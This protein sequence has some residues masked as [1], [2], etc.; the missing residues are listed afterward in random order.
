MDTFLT[1]NQ[2]FAKF[3]SKRIQKAVRGITGKKSE[4]M[5]GDFGGKVKRKK[6]KS[7]RET[8]SLGENEGGN[9]G[10]IPEE[11]NQIKGKKRGRKPTKKGEKKSKNE[12]ESES[13]EE[14]KVDQIIEEE[15]GKKMVGFPFKIII[16]FFHF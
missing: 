9:D 8:L 13:E 5:E 6:G 1:F 7:R 10:K 16:F 3:R 15:N 14:F 11:R 4:E 2:R 12:G